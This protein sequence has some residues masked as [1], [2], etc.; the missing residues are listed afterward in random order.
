MGSLKTVLSEISENSQE[1]IYA[2]ISFF[3]KV[4][5]QFH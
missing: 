1:N 3:D 4:D 2:G 5:L